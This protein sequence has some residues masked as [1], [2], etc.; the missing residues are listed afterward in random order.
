MKL[1]VYCDDPGTGGTAVNAVLLAEGLASSTCQTALACGYPAN[2]YVLAGVRC[3]PLPHDV[4]AGQDKT[5]RNHSEPQ[6]LFW[7]ERPDLVLFCDSEPESSL[8]AKAVCAGWGIPYVVLVN[9]VPPEFASAPPELLAQVARANGAA[10]AVIAV[11]RENL[12]RLH[13]FCGAPASR[14]HVIANGCADAFFLPPEAARRDSLRQA[15]GLAPDDVFCVTTGRYEPRKGYQYLL[16]AAAILA[17]APGGQRLRY[18]WLGHDSGGG[19]E[20]LAHQVAG[21]GLDAR[22]LLTGQRHDVADWLTAADIFVLP[23]E[24]EGMPLCI[25]EAMARGVPVVAT[26]VGGIPEQLGAAGVLLPDPAS[27]AGAVVDAL[28]R[29]LAWLAGDAEN[30][31][32]LGNAGRRRALSRFTARAML[33]AYRRLI[34]SCLPAAP[35]RYPDAATFCPANG[36]RPGVDILLGDEAQAVEWLQEGWSHG[37][38]EGRWTEGRRARLACVFP[39]GEAQTWVLRIEG[40]P[41]VGD[42]A[43]PLCLRLFLGERELGVWRWPPLPDRD[44]CFEFLLTTGQPLP[45]RRDLVFDITGASSPCSRGISD[46]TRSLGLWITC[47]RFDRLS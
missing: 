10:A 6:A 31:L 37:E 21:R 19:R 4:L 34:A 30:R 8:A 17:A 7:A 2:P 18:A 47:I 24:A 35:P 28:V 16:Q 13:A 20:A 22:V 25:N 23:S 1:L 46:D 41:F 32:R 11:S 14:S 27:G 9:F 42:A 12:S 3:L 39:A 26:A 44:F 33:D 36:V 38:G 15:L 5:R 45:A 40:K 43:A 29:N